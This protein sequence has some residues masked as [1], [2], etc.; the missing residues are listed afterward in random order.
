MISNEASERLIAHGG[1]IESEL[2]GAAFTRRFCI[3]RNGRFGQVRNNTRKGDLVC[4]VV[5]AQVPLVIRPPD[6]G[7]DVQTYELIGDCYLE[8]V[9]HGEAM[10]DERYETVEIILK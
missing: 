8:G 3:T 9:M 6:R 2:F 7:D 1:M 5:G 4:V 10:H